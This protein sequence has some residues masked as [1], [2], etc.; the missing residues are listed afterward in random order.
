MGLSW[1]ENTACSEPPNFYHVSFKP[2]YVSDETTEQLSGYVERGVFF[3][4]DLSQFTIRIL[5]DV[6]SEKKGRRRDAFF[7]L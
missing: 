5:F 2:F 1:E 3:L 7:I 4:R 6:F